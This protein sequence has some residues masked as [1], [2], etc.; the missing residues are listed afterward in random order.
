MGFFIGINIVIFS[1]IGG[2]LLS[3]GQ[4]ILLFQPFEFLIIGGSAFGAFVIS[5]PKTLILKVFKHFPFLLKGSIYTKK[6]YLDLLGAIYMLLIKAKIEGLMALENDIENP[7]DSKILTQ[8][9]NFLE[10]Q[11][12]LEFLTDHMRLMVSGV[13]NVHELENLMDVELDTHEQESKQV[14]GA[15]MHVADGLPGFG[16]VAAV[17]GV[18]ITMS[19]LDEPPEVLGMHIGAALVGTFLGILLAYGFVGP[20]GKSL[21][22][23]EIEEQR[24]LECIKICLVAS[25]NNYSPQLAIEFG[26]KAIFMDSRPGFYELEDH[27]KSIKKSIT[28]TNSETNASK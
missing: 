21:E 10:Q 18:V 24:Y 4:L 5:S 27:V 1:V 28:K 9:P 26:R 13:K 23:K 11:R 17:L 19:A 22:Y 14:S 7:L 16:I 20:M 12:A 15:I 2:Y 6:S 3:H 8:F 25:L